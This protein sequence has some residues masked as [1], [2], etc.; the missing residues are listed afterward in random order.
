MKI[1]KSLTAVVSGTLLISASSFA[2]PGNHLNWGYQLNATENACPP[3]EQVLKVVRKVINALDSGTGTN[4]DGKAW[5]ANTEYVQQIQVVHTGY[6]DST[7]LDEFCAKVKSQGS[8]ES[9]GGDGPG[10]ANDSNCTDAVTPAVP[11]GRLYPGVMG[12]FQGGYINTFEG[13]FTPGNRRTKGSIGTLD[14]ECHASTAEGCPASVF[15]AW[16]SNYFNNVSVSSL[17]WWGWVYHAGDN[18]SWVNKT[19][20]NEG[21]ITGE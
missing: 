4:D 12:T 6:N 13:K 16:R 2:A 21:N 11:P 9:V 18:G 8:F 5:W 15:S 19:D 10:C 14:G 20:G 3:G 17:P 7:G 1:M